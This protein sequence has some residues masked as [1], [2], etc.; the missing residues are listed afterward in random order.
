[1]VMLTGEMCQVCDVNDEYT[2]GRNKDR[3]R[4]LLYVYV[5]YVCG[6]DTRDDV[7]NYLQ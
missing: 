7:E 5:G 2:S 6:N 4:F 3:K 1:M